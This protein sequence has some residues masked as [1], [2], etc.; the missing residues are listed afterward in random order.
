MNTLRQN[1]P[2]KHDRS[3]QEMLRIYVIFDKHKADKHKTITV[4]STYLKMSLNDTSKNSEQWKRETIN[5]YADIYYRTYTQKNSY[6]FSKNYTVLLAIL[7][8][9]F[10]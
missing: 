3:V 9:S 5:V 8:Q 2:Q 4:L 10:I 6:L 1:L 7:L